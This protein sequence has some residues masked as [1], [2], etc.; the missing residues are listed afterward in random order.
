MPLSSAA[1]VICYCRRPP[2]PLSLT[3]TIVVCR[4]HVL[5]LQPSSP[6]RCLHRLSLPSLILLHR[7]LPPNLACRCRLPPS[8]SAIVVVCHR[9]TSACPPSYLKMLIVALCWPCCSSVAEPCCCHRHLS[10]NGAADSCLQPSSPPSPISLCS[11]LLNST[12]PTFYL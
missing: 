5:P 10:S 6:H 12:W 11:L 3:T 4:C 7:S 1:F 9:R 2:S 8:S